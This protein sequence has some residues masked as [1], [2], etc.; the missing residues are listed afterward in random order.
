MNIY[1]TKF[2]VLL[3]F[4]ICGFIG[5]SQLYGQTVGDVESFFE[6]YKDVYI[7]QDDSDSTKGEVHN[8]WDMGEPVKYTLQPSNKKITLDFQDNFQL[9]ALLDDEFDNIV[10]DITIPSE[11]KKLSLKKSNSEWEFELTT[12]INTQYDLFEGCK[13]DIKNLKLK[14]LKD[15]TPKKIYSV[16]DKTVQWRPKY[17]W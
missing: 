4:I 8:L 12:P 5:F 6:E 15:K 17:K 1:Y 13:A 9:L 11:G 2:K 14:I 7:V 16:E 10:P 3:S